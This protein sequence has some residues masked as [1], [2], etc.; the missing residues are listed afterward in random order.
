MLDVETVAGACPGSN[1]VMYFSN[2]TEQGWVEA[3]DP[4]VH[5]SANE[6]A[7]ISVSFGLAEGAV[8]W[9]EQAMELVNDSL[10]TAA[11]LGIPVCIAS[12][13]DGSDDQVG[14][15]AHTSTFQLPAPSSSRLAISH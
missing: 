15:G 1:I 2:F 4:A 5:D 9:T 7:S 8:I 3:V 6:L 12:G 10:K 14:D 13:D 11:A